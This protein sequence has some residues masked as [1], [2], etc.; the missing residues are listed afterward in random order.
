MTRDQ[1]Y[2]Y[3]IAKYRQRGTLASP[4]D[5]GFNRLAW[6]LPYVAGLSG[7]ALVGFVAVRWTRRTTAARAA[8]RR[9]PA[10][11]DAGDEPA[12]DATPGR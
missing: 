7:A 5:S 9:R 12:F 3:Y 2:G 4:I 10:S 11:A 1:I 6:A 8:C